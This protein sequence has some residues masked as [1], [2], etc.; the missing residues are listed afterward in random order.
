[1]TKRQIDNVVEQSIRDNARKVRKRMEL[2]GVVNDILDCPECHRRL[3]G[4]A[5][6]VIG[7]ERYHLLCAIKVHERDD[8]KK[9]DRAAK[10][11]RQFDTVTIPDPT[12]DE[13]AALEA[14][15]EV[16]IVPDIVAD[17]T[18]PDIT[19]MAAEQGVS[20]HSLGTPARIRVVGG[21][22]PERIGR[23]GVIATSDAKCYPWVTHGR[24]E[25]VVLLDDDPLAGPVVGLE[26]EWTCVMD[27]GDV[28]ML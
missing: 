18:R 3:G 11:A 23:E 14:E 15:L 25:V 10:R 4:R 2:V 1:M 5:T 19:I 24:N 21:P 28:E 6:E 22:W 7:N 16:D 27:R 13:L 9:L 26:D 8:A 17:N 20:D 12:D